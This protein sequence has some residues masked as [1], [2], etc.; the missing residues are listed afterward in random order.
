MAGETAASPSLANEIRWDRPGASVMLAWVRL[1]VL[2]RRKQLLL[3][4]IAEVLQE[5]DAG[6]VELA[7]PGVNKAQRAG[8]AAAG[9]GERVAGI[10]P[11]M[12]LTGDMRVVGKARVEE[13][14]GDDH[15][16][17]LQNGVGAERRLA[18]RLVGR[19]AV[20]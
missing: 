5:A 10:E 8:A 9:Q 19:K 1:G 20:T 17:A 18:W 4:Q 12:R 15:D 2:C 6:L 16:L 3:D 7:R 11:D 13:R 14:V